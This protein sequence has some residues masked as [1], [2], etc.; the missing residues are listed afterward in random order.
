MTGSL[1]LG[2]ISQI[3]RIVRNIQE[4]QTWFSEVLGLKHLYS[5]GNLAFFDCGGIRLFLSEAEDSGSAES[6]IYFNVADIRSAH[7]ELLERGVEFLG[8]PHMIHRH[9]DGTEEWMAAFKDN[10]GRPLAIS[11]RVSRS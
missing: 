1:T 11:S 5:F 2:T 7:A 4:A 3:S 8:A 6:I 10:E 9:S